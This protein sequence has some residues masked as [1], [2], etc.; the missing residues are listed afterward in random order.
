MHKDNFAL[1]VHQTS[2][3]IAVLCSIRGFPYSLNND[4]NDKHLVSPGAHY[5]IARSVQLYQ[6]HVTAFIQTRLFLDPFFPRN[7]SPLT[8]QKLA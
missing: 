4:N 5:P 7:S 3:Y 6:I 8:N 1:N 2:N